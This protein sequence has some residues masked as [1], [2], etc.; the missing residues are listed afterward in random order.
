[1]S[2]TS[3]IPNFKTRIKILT[4]RNLLTPISAPSA[5][6]PTLLS[7]KP[8]PAASPKP[9]MS[10]S[11][12]VLSTAT[13]N[14]MTSI[15]PRPKSLNGGQSPTGS[16][17]SLKPAVKLFLIAGASPTGAAR[18]PVSPSLLIS[19][20]L[21]S[22]RKCK[23]WMASPIPGHPNPSPNPAAPPLCRVLSSLTLLVMALILFN[24]VIF[25]DL[26]RPLPR[27]ARPHPLLG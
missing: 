25:Y 26:P 2:R 18:P 14:T 13:M 5:A 3:M 22:P 20:S 24:E 6:S 12:A 4:F 11:V 27:P 15:P 17:K 7:P 19:L 23:S 9:F 21:P 8:V 1:M 16:V 10:A